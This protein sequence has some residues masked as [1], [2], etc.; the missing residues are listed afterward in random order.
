MKNL[1]D[2]NWQEA[3]KT[4]QGAVVIDVR[5][6]DEWQEGVI[7]NSL[8]INIMEQQ[9]FVNRIAELDKSLPYFVYCRSGARSGQA[10][11]YMH[12]IGFNE[13][14]NLNGGI[15]A[16]SGQLETPKVL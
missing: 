12:Q 11:G 10:C 9:S 6:P 4:T 7:P 14:V 5:T 1:N 2:K 3:L 16:F 8:L 13:V 15:L